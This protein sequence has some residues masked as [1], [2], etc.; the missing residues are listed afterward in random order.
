MA[1]RASSN[2]AGLERTLKS[3]VDTGRLTDE[4]EALVALARGLAG[5]V[6][7]EPGNAA[8]WREY[9]AAVASLGLLGADKP[10]DDT[11]EFMLSI[12]TPVR[13]TVGHPEVP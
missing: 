6:D 1:R 7:A 9:R 4:D 12:R 5:A 11:H 3:L 13:P 8:L 10:D 2:A